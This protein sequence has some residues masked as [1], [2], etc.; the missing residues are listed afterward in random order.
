MKK[1]TLYILVF[2]ALASGSCNDF[3]NPQPAGQIPEKDAFTKL[4]DCQ[5]TINGIYAIWNTST[6]YSG[7][8]TLIPDLQ[9]DMAYPVVGFMGAGQAMFEWSYTP[10]TGETMNIF[11]ALYRINNTVNFLLENYHKAVIKEEEKEELNNIL[12]AAY[13]SRA[14]AVCELVKYYAPAYDPANAGNQPG[15]PIQDKA[16]DNTVKPARATLAENYTHILEDLTMAAKLCTLDEADA[17]YITKGAIDA[18]YARVY[19]YMEN[20]D[21][22]AKAAGRVIGNKKYTLADATALQDETNPLST[23]FSVMWWFD[24]GTEIIWKL[25]YTT[26]DYPGSL[27]K[28]FTFKNGADYKIEYAPA[29]SIL[30]MYENSNTAIDL[31]LYNYFTPATLENQQ[32]MILYKYPGNKDLETGSPLYANMPKV[33]RL[34]EMYLIRAEAYARMS[35]PKTALANADLHLLR[36]KRI[37]G[38]VK[39]DLSGKQL[40][41]AIKAERVKELIMEGHRFY[42]LKRYREGFNRKPQ[43]LSIAPYDALSVKS[44]NNRWIWPIP[45]HEV[46]ANPNVDQNPGY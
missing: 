22:A 46:D 4:S 24:Q 34:A 31:R 8:L 15:V 27:G 18:L 5:A 3:L 39:R 9:C 7:N 35:S 17:I 45:K 23:L 44:D 25:K 1:F 37:M 20:W 14:L 42:D 41:D 11:Y 19:L 30:G 12:A 2:L 26:T 33:F 28:L 10:T 32:T 38:Y 40:T 16:N 21:E 36:G 43:Y 6:L 29:Q 13:F